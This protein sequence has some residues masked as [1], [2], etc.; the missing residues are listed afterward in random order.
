MPDLSL[1]EVLALAPLLVLT[2]ATG[3]APSW[4]LDTIH[5]TTSALVL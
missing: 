2:V 5:R 4:V 1:R 3:V